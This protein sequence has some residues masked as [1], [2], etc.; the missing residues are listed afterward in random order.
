MKKSY[1]IYSESD[2]KRKDN[3]LQ[4]CTNNGNKKDIPIETVSDIY[5]M[6]EMGF[7]T[8]L[9]N[10]LSK[11]GIS[12]HFFNYYNFYTGS[13][14]PKEQNIS[15][16]LLVKQVEYFSDE[17]KRLVLAKEFVRGATE[18]ILRNLRYYNE[19]GKNVKEFIEIIS[20][21]KR[22]IDLQTNISELMGIEGNIHKV[23][24]DSWNIIIDKEIN[25]EKR[26]KRPPDN[27]INTLISFVNTLIYTTV[28]S[29]IYITQLNPTVSYL[30]SPGDRRFSLALDIAEI[31]KPLIGDR[32]IFSLLNKKQITEKH[33]IEVL[34]YLQFTKQGSQI[35]LK[36][37]EDRLNKTIKHK[38]LGKS[39][40]Y[41][42]LI[43]LEA[44]K[45]V[46]H[47]MNEKEYESFKLWW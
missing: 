44:Y 1:F 3:T 38:T 14:Y 28:L 35:V 47:L 42:Y 33:F 10:I 19:R 31:F 27:L 39:V 25:F 46:K 20:N 23:Y 15:G 7:N 29:Q 22:H 9:I 21:L 30:H 11:Y 40:S 6:T 8:S 16:K 5:V 13:F 37:Y 43:R 26:V 34:N 24:Y 2:L 18:G 36:E 32:M 17:D 41:K 12:V 45:L 4:I